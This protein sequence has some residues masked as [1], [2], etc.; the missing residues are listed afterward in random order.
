MVQSLSCEYAE[1][2]LAWIGANQIGS[3]PTKDFHFYLLIIRELLYAHG[4]E[5]KR[6][7]ER[8]RPALTAIQQILAQQQNLMMKT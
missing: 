2:L 4:M 1:C 3:T 7:L 8:N 6:S 5:F